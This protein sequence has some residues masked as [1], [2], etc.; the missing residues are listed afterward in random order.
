MMSGAS[1][2]VRYVDGHFFIVALTAGVCGDNVEL[3]LLVAVIVVVQGLLHP[4]WPVAL[5]I[6][7]K[8]ESPM[9][10]DI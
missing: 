7:K 10:V 2:G 6:L 3:V 8:A 1:F 5:S 4:I 9:V